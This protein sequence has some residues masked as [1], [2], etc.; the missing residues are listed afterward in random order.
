M[1]R[2]L[3]GIAVVLAGAAPLAEPPVAS[4]TPSPHIVGTW[5]DTNESGTG[6]W[7]LWSNGKVVAIDG[8]AFYGDARHAGYNNFVGM[9]ASDELGGQGYW[10][11]TATGV[12]KSFGPACG[13]NASLHAPA[14]MPTSGIVGLIEGTEN[15]AFEAVSSK[16][17][18]YA[19]K[20]EFEV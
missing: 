19:F 17:A 14:K 1:R 6:G 9:L 7:L 11:V 15:S 18:T 20:C 4:A 16:G 2:L 8:A 10:L 5:P 13:D 3:V 12:V